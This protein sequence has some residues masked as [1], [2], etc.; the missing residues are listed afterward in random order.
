M[1]TLS[2]QV[3]ITGITAP[4]YADILQQLRISYWGIYGSDADLDD[5]TQDGQ[6][7]AILAQ[8]IH[9]CN[10]TAI[11]VFNAFS[12]ATAQGVGLS[13]VI[14]INGLR[15]NIP[16]NSQ[17]PVVIGGQVGT[18][19]NNGRVGDNL[20][21]G[22]TWNLPTLVTIPVEGVVTVTATCASAGSVDA[23]AGTLTVILTPTR[24]WQTVT[25]PD[26]AA[27]GL[28]VE[29]DATL[30]LRQSKSVALP[31]LTI[32]ESIFA[33][34]DAVQGVGRLRIYENDADVTDGNG[35]PDHSI[36]VVSSGG[37]VT[38]IATAIANEK[39]PGTGTYGT[40]V[41]VVEDQNGVPNTI[42]FFELTESSLIFEIDV[43]ALAGYVSTT[44]DLLKQSL[45]DFVNAYGIGETSY[46][47]RAYSPANLGGAGLGATF[48][49]TAIKQARTGNVLG[50]ANI[51]AVF[52]E[53]F[54]LSLGNINL[55]VA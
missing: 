31:A 9:D 34:V 22:T 19:I 40:T 8:I 33:A 44:G 37:D 41:V 43:T 20:N 15:R 23:A 42:R 48:V 16:T 7:L 2:A 54:T 45:A 55:V 10:Q 30:R 28:P 53:A 39:S 50:T 3:S 4:D 13:N 52:N 47:S 32:L 6:F 21:L 18:Q 49:V 35:I 24:G 51:V 11:A 17:S 1:A 14:K 12:P 29:N 26:E 25:N 38:Q 27:P 5:D 36:A 46:T